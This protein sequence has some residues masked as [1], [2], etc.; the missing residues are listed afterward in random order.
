MRFKD[1]GVDG[2]DTEEYA[3]G[4]TKQGVVPLCRVNYEGTTMETTGKANASNTIAF[5]ET[6]SFSKQKDRHIIKALFAPPPL[7]QPMML[8]SAPLDS[9]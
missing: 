7:C 3:E 8:I 1:V 9:R 6:L 2:R 5:N 4:G